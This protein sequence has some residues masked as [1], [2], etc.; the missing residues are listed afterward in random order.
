MHNA[1]NR[2]QD[3]ESLKRLEALS[4]D[5]NAASALRGLIEVEIGEL[6]KTESHSL[7][8]RR[9]AYL[10]EMLG[11]IAEILESNDSQKDA[12]RTNAAEELANLSLKIENTVDSGSP[13]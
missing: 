13:E 3:S 10:E 1:M 2:I 7:R 11:R 8:E 4:R 5:P 6:K 12:V 9:I